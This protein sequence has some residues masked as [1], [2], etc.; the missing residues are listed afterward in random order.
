MSLT[1]LSDQLWQYTTDITQFT[2]AEVLFIY[3]PS[4]S[5]GKIW[6]CLFLQQY[7]DREKML[8][9]SWKL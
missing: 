9:W 8:G 5:K 3:T 4:L 2:E 7:G 6:C 1:K